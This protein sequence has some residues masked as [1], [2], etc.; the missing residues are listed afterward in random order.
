MKGGRAQGRH[1]LYAE[2]KELKGAL[3]NEM[4]IVAIVSFAVIFISGIL[5]ASRRPVEE[6]Q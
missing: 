1:F 4:E 2:A 5:W 6:H 3:E